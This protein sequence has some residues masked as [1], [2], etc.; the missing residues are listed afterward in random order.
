[1]FGP[2]QNRQ[3][4]TSALLNHHEGH[5][6]KGRLEDADAAPS[7]PALDMAGVGCRDVAAHRRMHVTVD[8]FGSPLQLPTLGLPSVSDGGLDTH[9]RRLMALLA[10]GITDEQAAHEL[11][12]SRRTLQRRLK[13]AMDKLGARSRLEAGVRLVRQGWIDVA[14]EAE[15]LPIPATHSGRRSRVPVEASCSPSTSRTGTR[16]GER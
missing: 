3:V 7:H 12:W 2:A 1:M 13:S 6:R 10:T 16:R 4:R 9:E 15:D 5:Y 8:L 11:G 14:E